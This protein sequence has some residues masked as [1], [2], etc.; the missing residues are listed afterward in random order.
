VPC[1]TP[2]YAAHAGTIEIDT[3]ESWSGRWLVK[4]TT[5]ASSLST[6]YAHMHTLTVSRGQTV[7]A[8]Q[9][10]GTVGGDSPED[11][12]S[13]GCHLHFEVHESNGPIYGADNVAPSQ[14]LANNTGN[15]TGDA[16]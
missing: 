3:A 8:G 4:V 12:N 2:V 16:S 10:I 7:S 6:W 5:G 13:S 11:G 1:G 14:W 15:N 9:Q